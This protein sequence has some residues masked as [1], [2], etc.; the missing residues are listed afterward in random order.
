MPTY[1]SKT[2]VSFMSLGIHDMDVVEKVTKDK[3]C[4]SK[5][6]MRD[7]KLDRSPFDFEYS[8]FIDILSDLKDERRVAQPCK[9]SYKGLLMI[10]AWTF[11]TNRYLKGNF[12]FTGKRLIDMRDWPIMAIMSK[13]QQQVKIPFAST[14]DRIES[15]SDFDKDEY[16]KELTLKVTAASRKPEANMGGL[17]S[18][19]K[20]KMFNPATQQYEVRT[21]R[22]ARWIFRQANFVA[23]DHLKSEAVEHMR[24]RV[25]KYDILVLLDEPNDRSEEFTIIE[26]DNNTIMPYKKMFMRSGVEREIRNQRMYRLEGLETI[27]DVVVAPQE[28]IDRVNQPTRWGFS[29]SAVYSGSHIKSPTVDDMK[30]RVRKHDYLD[31]PNSNGS[32]RRYVITEVIDRSSEP[33]RRICARTSAEQGMRAQRIF[34]MEGHTCELSVIA[35]PEEYFSSGQLR[36]AQPS[37][38]TIVGRY[39][40]P[41]FTFIATKRDFDSGVINRPGRI[42]D[43][44][45]PYDRVEV[46][47]AEGRMT[48]QV[49]GLY[50]IHKV[51]KVP[52]N[53][54]T[55]EVSQDFDENN[56]PEYLIRMRLADSEWNVWLEQVEESVS[57]GPTVE[58]SSEGAEW[59]TI[60]ASELVVGDQEINQYQQVYPD[61]A[62]V[63]KA[64]LRA[65][66]NTHVPI[67]SD[68]NYLVI[69]QNAGSN[70]VGDRNV[71]VGV[72]YENEEDHEGDELDEE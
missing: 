46:R 68:N 64:Q 55:M 13:F 60:P 20:V 10:M 33:H 34:R 1:V 72:K 38:V 25:R 63:A 62:E 14:M 6:S 28:A 30:N 29:Q 40:R 43:K 5:M 41:P 58:I 18:S 19:G 53:D 11:S 45:Y 23:A 7:G 52:N 24:G 2:R 22:P 4:I 50:V 37:A 31:V 71:C 70:V 47:G 61:P 9:I 35:V 27:L 54:G 44:P 16:L 42:P 56:H 36:S 66:P 48:L 15:D 57:Q 51:L 39:S 67:Y 8:D 17:V 69:D 32:Y 21:G 59:S 49:A 26:C 3:I 65:T 12:F